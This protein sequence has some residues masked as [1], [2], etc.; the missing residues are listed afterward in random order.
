MLREDLSLPL[1][2][3]CLICYFKCLCMI[4]PIFPM[5]ASPNPPIFVW[6][7]A[8]NPQQDSSQHNIHLEKASVLFNLGALCTHIALSCDLTTIQGR[9]LAMDALN[10]ALHWFYQLFA[11]GT[12]DLS[13]HYIHMIKLQFHDLESKFRVPQPDK[14]SLSGYPIS[15]YYPSTS[16]PPLAYDP[17][18]D[19]TQQFVL[20]YYN[21][22][23]LL[24]GVCQAAP[25]LDLL[26]EV[27]PV[28]IKDGNL[29]ANAATL[30]A[31]NLALENMSL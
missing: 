17:S 23:S 30:E 14:P 13:E 24:Q 29:V 19:V 16:G 11:S 18:S 20:G 7:N 22:H 2:R 27:S 3:D 5:N 31:P 10:D 21:A 4:E 26:S 6:Y 12:I 1:R 15:A 28:K 8:I 25:C 9:R